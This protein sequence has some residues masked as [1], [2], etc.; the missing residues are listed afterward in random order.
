MAFAMTS[1]DQLGMRFRAALSAFPTNLPYEYEEDHADSQTIR[2]LKETAVQWAGRGS[3]DNYRAVETQPG[4]TEISYESPVPLDEE[5]QAR[6]DDATAFIHAS[7]VLEWATRSL[8]QNALQS[9]LSLAQAIAFAREH[10]ADAMFEV[11]L[12]VGDHAVQSAI[13]SIAAC[14]IRF[15]PETGQDLEWAWEVMDRVWNMKERPLNGSQVPWHP[16]NHL[17]VALVHQ[18]STED[19]DAQACIALINLTYH[20]LEGISALAFAGLL[21]GDDLAI[22]RPDQSRA[23]FADGFDS[24]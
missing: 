15:G 22:D 13:S 4:L 10:D 3:L 20:P 9:S 6:Q 8:E 14:A 1:D 18:R 11:R 2:R 12:D 21:R 17:I 5:Q 19:S 16:F 23:V 7:N 24:I